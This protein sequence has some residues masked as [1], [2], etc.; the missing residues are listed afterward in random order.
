[1]RGLIV[2]LPPAKVSHHKLRL[3]D[4]VCANL[5]WCDMFINQWNGVSMRQQPAPAHHVYLDDSGLWKCR[6]VQFPRW[7]QLIWLEEWA[8]ENIAVKEFVPIVAAAAMWGINWKGCII[9]FHCDNDN[10]PCVLS[11]QS[12]VSTYQQAATL[13]SFLICS[14]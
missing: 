1:M 3:N 11:R 9:Q 7:L 14:L 12:K 10:C 5:L 4:E 13:L 8:S 6:T 2:L